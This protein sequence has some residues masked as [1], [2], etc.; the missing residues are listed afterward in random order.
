MAQVT[1]VTDSDDDDA[2]LP[3]REVCELRCQMFAEVT[4]TDTALAMFYLQD[5]GWIIERAIND[6]FADNGGSSVKSPPAAKSLTVTA[7]KIPDS[8]PSAKTPYLTTAPPVLQPKNDQRI[9]VLSWNIDGLDPDNLL[10]RAEGVCSVLLQEDPEVIFIQEAVSRSLQI[11]KSRCVGYDVFLGAEKELIV[12]GAYFTAMLVRKDCVK[13]ESTKLTSFPTSV[14][15]R[16]LLE[17]KCRL[18]N[19]PV[20]F[21]TSHLEST[22]EHSR[23]RQKQLKIAFDRMAAIDAEDTV[24]FGGDLNL[25]DKELTGVSAK[26]PGVYDV[27]ECT[28]KRPQAAY[29]WDLAMND[30]KLLHSRAQ[31]RCRFDRLYIRHGREYRLKPAYFELVGIQRLSSCQRFPSDHWGILGHFDV[32]S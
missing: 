4:G 25:R 23:E 6:Y 9:R 16:T 14:M 1:T 10:S 24:I 8:G 26:P 32:I 31:P 13:V 19:I 30:N 15:E 3:S 22:G 20:T 17:V 2:N 21:L 29:T 7:S 28:G 12:P 5:R 27:W 18:K 11:I